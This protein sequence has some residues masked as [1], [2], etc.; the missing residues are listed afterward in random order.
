MN[1]QDIQT[2]FKYNQWA[3]GK[4]LEAASHVSP[5]QFLADGAYPHGGLRGTLV[6]ILFAEWIWRSRWQG[7]SPTV[8]FRPDEFPTFE[9][10]KTRWLQEE[11]SLMQFVE[12]LNDEQLNRPFP[13]KTTKGVPQESI[14]WHAML[15]VLNHGTQ[16]RA[17]AAAMLTDFGCSP[18]DVDMIYFLQI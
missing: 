5:E 11:Q 18:G 14:L 2:L 16:H 12:E 10:L 17:E 1:N 9:S 15:H 7:S 13:Y 8:R 4:I 6:H 3:N